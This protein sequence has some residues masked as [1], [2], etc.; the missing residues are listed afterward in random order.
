MIAGG[1]VFLAIPFLWANETNTPLTWRGVA[2]GVAIAVLFFY[3]AAKYRREA[4]DGQ[5]PP[6]S[7][8]G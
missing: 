6:P 8:G 3:L 2:L 7:S 1:I 4:R 5:I